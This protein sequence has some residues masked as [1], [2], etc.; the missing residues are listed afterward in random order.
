MKLNA[1]LFS[2]MIKEKRNGMGL[3]ETAHQIGDV[4]ASTLSRI[5][6]GKIPDLQ[7]FFKICNW[8]KVPSD[9]FIINPRMDGSFKQSAESSL[10]NTGVHFRAEKELSPYVIN[11][12]FKMINLAAEESEI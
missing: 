5:E 6:K 3:R 8:L 4:S 7:T 11:S 10:E 1:T 2:E 12:V 9:N